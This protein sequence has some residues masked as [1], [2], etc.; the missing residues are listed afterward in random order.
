MHCPNCSDK[1]Y[2][3]FTLVN[4]YHIIQCVRCGLTYTK[5]FARHENKINKSI[6]DDSYIRNYQARASLIKDRFLD[7]L[8]LIE[9]YKQGGKLLDIGCSLGYFLEVV[10]TQSHFDWRTYGLEINIKLAEF[11]KSHTDS[12]VRIGA[13]PKLPYKAQ[14]FDC[15]T[16][17]DVLEH[18]K[19]INK[20]LREIRRVLKKDGIVVIQSPNYRSFMAAITGTKW[21]WWTPPDHIVHFSPGTLVSILGKNGFDVKFLH[22]YEYSS[23]FTKN[24]KGVFIR[25]YITKVFWYLF[26]PIIILLEKAFDFLGYGALILVVAYPVSST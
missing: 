21:D 8:K 5:L 3:P 16:C 10:N 18:S 13:L 20:N 15:I 17:F 12:T 2:R 9:R 4:K 1:G 22:T 23:D 6:Y 7:K 25:R 19:E 24:V 14:S 26:L 11:A